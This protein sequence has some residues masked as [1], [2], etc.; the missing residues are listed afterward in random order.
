M[1]TLKNIKELAVVN[2]DGQKKRP[3]KNLGRDA[4]APMV[5]VVYFTQVSEEIEEKVTNK[6]CL[7]NLIGQRVEF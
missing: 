7:R 4:N 3:R 5:N 6:I 1:A 2:R